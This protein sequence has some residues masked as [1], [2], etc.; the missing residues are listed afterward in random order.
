MSCIKKPIQYFIICFC[1]FYHLPAISQSSTRNKF[2]E[3]DYALQLNDYEKALKLFKQLLDRDPEN[4]LYNYRVGQCLLNLPDLKK[5]ALPYLEVAVKSVSEDFK[6]GNFSETNAPTE[7]YFLIAKACHLNEDLDNA[8]LYYNKYLY[9]VNDKSRIKNVNDQIIACGYAKSLINNPVSVNTEKLGAPINSE[10]SEIYPVISDD[11]SLLVYLEMKENSNI[12]FI[13]RNEGGQWTKPVNINNSI[14]SLNDSYPSSISNDKTR[15]YFSVKNYFTS[16]I[17]YSA[18]ENDRWTKMNK[19]KSPVNTKSWNSH[20]FESANGNE[21]Y[22]VS[23][24]KGGYGGLDIYKSVMN[25]KGKW[26]NPENLGSTINTDLNEIM[27]IIS[28]DEKTLYFCSEGHSSIGGYD[29]FLSVKNASKAWSEPANLGYP[30]NT[31]DDNVYFRPLNDGI[32]A[33]SSLPREDNISNYDIYRLEIFSDENP[34]D[35]QLPITSAFSQDVIEINPEPEKQE[36]EIMA[37][38]ITDDTIYNDQQGIQT[39]AED[40]E[41]IPD[42]NDI[43]YNKSD[44]LSMYDKKTNLPAGSA[45]TDAYIEKSEHKLLYTIQIMALKKPVRPDFFSNIS[46]INIQIGDDGF[47][48]YVTGQFEDINHTKS[49]LSRIKT[50]GYENAFVRK[51]DLNQYLSVYNTASSQPSDD[52]NIKQAGDYYTIQI[53]ALK[54]P[55]SCSYFENLKDIKVSYGSDKIFRY[56]YNEYPSYDSAVAGLKTLKSKG[57][58]EAFIKKVSDISNY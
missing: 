24:R 51:L 43:A 3:A 38:S 54:N 42:E 36:E 10:S 58:K 19:L 20:A 40:Y 29:V 12:V 5:T 26:G 30:I 15:I 13:T 34:Q 35:K 32:F 48:R 46:G 22:F 27:P 49:E 14:G 41:V 7:T 31:T 52:H 45:G 25:S 37:A 21:L 28:P 23:D 39:T 56:T 17:C 9:Y 18:L 55:V 6:E 33:Y 53:M 47:Y 50:L 4:A 2:F 57:Y 16:T 8:I 1:L 44:D 11:E